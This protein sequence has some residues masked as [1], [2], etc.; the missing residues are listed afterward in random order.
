MALY[1]TNNELLIENNEL[2]SKIKKLEKQL[3]A[4]NK[5]TLV[6]KNRTNIYKNRICQLVCEEHQNVMK[7]FEWCKSIID[8]ADECGLDMEVLYDLLPIWYDDRTIITEAKDYEKC[9]ISVMGRKKY[10]AEEEMPSEEINIRNR[11]PNLEEMNR[12]I[13]E[14]NTKNM[15]LYNLADNY[16]LSI[17]NL[18]RLL[19]ENKLIE[20][21]TDANGYNIFY[22]EYNGTGIDWDFETGMGLI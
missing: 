15:S 9:M 22:T 11:T 10:D 5:R 20:N 8:T 4:S 1:L 13:L 18:F 14:Y 21:E 19:R 2:K 3:E 16:N 7:T 6:Y 12:I 17:N